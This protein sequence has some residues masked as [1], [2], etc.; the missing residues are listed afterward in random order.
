MKFYFL[1]H[2]RIDDMLKLLQSMGYKCVAPRYIEG[3]INYAT[4][5]NASELPWGLQ[6]EQAPGHYKVFKT[7]VNRAFAHTVPVQSVKPMLFKPKENVWKVKR[8]DEGKLIFEPQVGFEKIAVF[9]IRACDLRAIEVQ[10]K[11][12]MENDF[13]DIRYI[14]RRENQ[15]LIAMNCTH[16]H[17]N[18]FCVSLGDGPKANDKAH[19]LSMTE[20]DGGFVVEIGSDKGRDLLNNLNLGSASSAQEQ[21]VSAGIQC[22]VEEQ[23]KTI[24]P[25]HIVEKKLM[26]NLEHPRWDDVASRCLSCGNCTNACP[27]CFCHTERDEPNVSGDESNHTREWDSCFTLDH[28]YTHG[29]TVRPETKH[30][31]RQWLTHKFATWRDQFKVYGCV[32][33][34]RCVTWC[35]VKIDVTEEI[36]HICGT[37]K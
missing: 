21:S 16:S 7:G 30:R 20:I 34:G 25:T 35:P 26:A 24:P 29:E 37:S 22:A 18:C 36:N 13:N 9:G 31:Y 5:N 4:L 6:D 27:T 23:I 28:S 10:D 17:S 14:K 8:N 11:T 1:S 19:D 32:G 15:F 3:T 33:C 12:F 2:G